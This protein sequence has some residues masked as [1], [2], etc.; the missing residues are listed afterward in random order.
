MENKNLTLEVFK[1]IFFKFTK[2]ILASLMFLSFNS[3]EA[4][5]GVDV[6]FYTGYPIGYYYDCSYPGCW[7]GWGYPSSAY[8]PY[9]GTYNY[10]PNYYYSVGYYDNYNTCRAKC[11]RNCTRKAD[12]SSA[13]CR[14]MCRKKCA[15]DTDWRD[16][17]RHERRDRHERKH[18]HNKNC[19]CRK[20]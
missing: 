13:D 18:R 9:W 1:T 19:G 17:R 15:G 5:V 7:Y 10:T 12:M 4:Y 16:K 3:S 6:G 20:I 2:Y 8:A 11:Y 14:I